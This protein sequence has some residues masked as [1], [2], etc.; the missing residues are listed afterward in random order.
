MIDLSSVYHHELPDFIRPYLE[1]EAM[2]R[3]RKV[4]M[5]CGMNYTSFPRFLLIEPYT[6]FHHSLSVA[7]I[8]WHFTEDKTQTLA[9]LFHDISSPAFSHVID[10]L[11]KDYLLQEATESKTEAFIKRDRKIMRLLESDGIR[12]EEVMDYHMYPIADNDSP[13]LCAD[14]LEYT[15]GD[16]ICFD[17]AD[18]QTVQRLYND[19]CVCTNEKGLCELG[20]RHIETACEFAMYALECGKVYVSDEDRFGMEYLASLLRTA[21]KRAIITD[22]D[23]FT[24]EEQVIRIIEN[25]ELREEWKRFCSFR[26]VIRCTADDPEGIIVRAKKRYIDP[27]AEG[28]RLSMVHEGFRREAEAFINADDSYPMK[29]E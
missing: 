16:I 29:G 5:N 23:L 26:R 25:S 1:T 17:L 7:M 4:D 21:M 2:N 27:L 20:F 10:F 6:R 28:K 3:I 14:R 12:I 24:D 13:A 19:L 11:Y 9:A 8:V 18:Q 15:L 22:D